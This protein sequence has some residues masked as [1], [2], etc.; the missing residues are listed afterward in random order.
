MRHREEQKRPR[1][2]CGRRSQGL[3]GVGG[4]GE[5]PHPGEAEAWGP[6]AVSLAARPL[7]QQTWGPW[8]LLTRVG[9][10]PAGFGAHCRKRI[11]NMNVSVKIGTKGIKATAAAAGRRFERW[12]SR[13]G[14]PPWLPPPPRPLKCRGALPIFRDYHSQ[15][16]GTRLLSHSQMLALAHCR[17]VC[18][19]SSQKVCGAGDGA[20]GGQLGSV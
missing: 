5:S 9:T 4:G 8:W 19:L 18:Q 15:A 16:D 6:Q 7:C 11:S 13:G 1:T 2:H 3:G 12:S 20:D 17:K 14:A 10:G